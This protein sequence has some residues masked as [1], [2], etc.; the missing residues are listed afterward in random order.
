MNSVSQR[1]SH[2]G[3]L[4]EGVSLRVSHEGYLMEGASEGV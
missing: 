3:C 2:G 4:T 1:V